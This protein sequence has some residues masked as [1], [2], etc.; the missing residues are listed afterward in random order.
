M[1]DTFFKH[2]EN[3]FPFLRQAK[4]LIAV[5]GGIDSIVLTTLCNKLELDITLA[6]CNFNLRGKESD[7]DEQFVLDYGNE[8]DKEV[9]VEHFNTSEYAEK[10]KLSIQ[11][12][13]RELRYNWFE[14]L[15]EALL[16]DY[17]LT[18]HHADDSL[19]TFIINLSRGTGIDGIKGIPA[20]NSSIVRPLL[21]FSRE[22]IEAY[23]L[24]NKIAWREDYSN[25]DTKYLRNKIRHEVVPV[26]KEVNPQFLSNFLKTQNH[27]YEST[28][29]IENEIDR[30]QLVLF[31]KEAAVYKIKI[32]KL[33]ELKPLKAYL[34]AL[35]KDF[36]FTQWNDVQDLLFAQ[37]GKQLF[38]STHRMIKDRD[39]LLVDSLEENVGDD[40]KI[41]ITKE[42]MVLDTPIHLTFK[43]VK[44]IEETG[45]HIIY[46]DKETL[47]FPLVVRKWKIGDYFYPYGLKGKKKI[48]KF[49]KDEK[50]S[51]IAKEQQWLLCSEDDIMWIIKKRADNRFKITEK[52]TQVLKIQIHS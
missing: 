50:L 25:N 48:S 4:I 24:K 31:E 33:L 5:S 49:F 15:K 19:E 10:H 45:D 12:A 29:I 17:V 40:R 52:T 42:N 51:L 11:M 44:E 47:N 9:F 34:Y 28:Q 23:A 18:A 14:D 21:V 38:S 43:D 30:L 37:S 16:F 26:L 7:A 6:H 32:A 35:F 8:L 39:F 36:D 1:L 20:V 46:V 22:E 41:V 13:A 27:L 3:N 2:I